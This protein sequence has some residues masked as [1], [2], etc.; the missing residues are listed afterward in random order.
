MTAAADQLR[1][2]GIVVD[3]KRGNQVFD[4]LLVPCVPDMFGCIES[5]LTAKAQRTPRSLA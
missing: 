4:S 2:A 1:H 5:V 3:E